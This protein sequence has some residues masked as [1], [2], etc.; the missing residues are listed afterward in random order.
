[1][2]TP[3]K[4]DLPREAGMTPAAELRTLPA[5]MRRLP[6]WLL[7]RYE[8]RAG[9]TKPRKMPYYASGQRRRGAQ[10]SAEDRAALATFEHILDAAQIG[11]WSGI[12]FAFL[13]G[14]G[15]VGIDIDGAIDSGNGEMSARC[16]AVVNACDS[17]TEYSP[18]GRGVHIVVQGNVGSFKTDGVEVYCGH[19][20]FTCTGR[21]CPGSPPA[22][23]PIGTDAWRLLRAG[24]HDAKAH[25]HD[26]AHRNRR[27]GGR[28]LIRV[29]LAD[30]AMEIA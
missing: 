29:T 13:P 19:Q 9:D 25:A 12:G 4:F 27:A 17:Y 10:G 14:D 26:H 23:Q 11:R 22:V 24:T 1:M 6:Q 15:L 3:L 18:S 8:R 30:F 16:R 7:W 21:Q 2:Q 20:F 5:Q 28:N